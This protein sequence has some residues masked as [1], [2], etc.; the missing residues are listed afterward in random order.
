MFGMLRRRCLVKELIGG[1]GWRDEKVGTVLASLSGGHD[2]EIFVGQ[3]GR[4]WVSGHAGREDGERLW[5]G[6]SGSGRVVTSQSVNRKEAEKFAKLSRYWW[7]PEGPFK[8][9]HQMNRVRCEFIRDV[10]QM[11]AKRRGVP[12]TMLRVLDVGCGG[13]IL[14]ESV[15]R[16][17]PR[18]LGIDVNTDGIDVARQHA[19]TNYTIKDRIEYKTESLESIVEKEEGKFDLVI[20]SE[21]IEHVDCVVDFCGSLARA[22][23]PG[24]SIIIST[25]NRTPVS[26]ATA[27]V[28]AEYMLQWVPQ[29]THTWDAFVTP[30]ELTHWMQKASESLSEKDVELDMIAGMSYQP[31]TGLWYLGRNLD[32]NYIA[33]FSTMAKIREEEEEEQ[34]VTEPQQR[35]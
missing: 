31:I 25:L 5:N 7:D 16:M 3:T 18:V 21:V 17:G 11:M 4:R 6:G 28:G 15:A 27:I 20:A 29:G 22:V 34:G 1:K 14:S 13:G 24:G 2:G 33:L 19:D 32:V 8:P 12:K 9:L 10:L 35:T 23:A 26:Y 30:E